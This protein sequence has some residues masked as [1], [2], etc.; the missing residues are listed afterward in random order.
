MINEILRSYILF[1]NS[2]KT[3]TTGMSGKYD[4]SL[5]GFRRIL[6]TGQGI[7]ESQ[8]KKMTFENFFLKEKCTR[9]AEPRG[10]KST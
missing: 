7:Q 4:R 3:S 8:I 2:F 10:K 5:Q 6:S 1:N 9:S